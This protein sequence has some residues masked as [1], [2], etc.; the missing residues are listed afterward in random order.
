M[1]PG[2]SLQKEVGSQ[3]KGEDCSTLSKQEQA[4]VFRRR[5]EGHGGQSLVTKAENRMR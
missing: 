5:K 1:T 2:H 3:A 4:G